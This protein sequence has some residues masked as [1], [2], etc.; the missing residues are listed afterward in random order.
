[1]AMAVVTVMSMVAVM[2]PV[3]VTAPMAAMTPVAAPPTAPTPTPPVLAANLLSFAHAQN[4][5]AI[6]IDRLQ[7]SGQL[8]SCR[9]DA[10]LFGRLRGRRCR[11]ETRH[12]CNQC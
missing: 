1:M 2:A 7:R 10:G 3:A 4:L 5:F 9:L 8:G 12:H 6:W 11:P